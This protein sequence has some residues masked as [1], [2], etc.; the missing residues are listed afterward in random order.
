MRREREG[1]RR[2]RK[3]TFPSCLPQ[4]RYFGAPPPCKVGFILLIADMGEVEVLRGVEVK[5]RASG[6]T[7]TGMSSKP[8]LFVEKQITAMWCLIPS[9]A[10]FHLQYPSLSPAVQY[11]DYL[12]V[13]DI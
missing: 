7:E 3:L 1:K 10:L 6:H 8:G 4:L 9:Q 11:V 2:S 12:L 5:H 13:A